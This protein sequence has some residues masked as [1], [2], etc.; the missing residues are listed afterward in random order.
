M[1]IL[2]LVLVLGDVAGNEAQQELVFLTWADY[3]DPDVVAEFEAEEGVKVQFVYF[4]SDF[5][6]NEILVQTQAQGFDVA[7]VDGGSIGVVGGRGWLMPVS[8]QT[9][10]NLAHTDPAQRMAYEGGQ[11]YGVPYTW[12]TIGIAY[13]ADLVEQ[14]IESWMQ[15]FRPEPALHGKIVMIEDPRELVGMALKA[16]GH[17]INSENLTELAEAER[18]LQEQR[19]LV[20]SYSYVSLTER[21]ALV[22]GE[23]AAAMVYNGDALMLQQYEPNI[24]FV[25][26]PEGTGMWVDYLAVLSSSP[27]KALAA[28]FIDFMNRPEIAA[29]NAEYLYYATPNRAA[30]RLLPSE[31]LADDRIYPNAE[32]PRRSEPFVTKLA[33][34]AVKARQKIYAR[35]QR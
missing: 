31:F 29:R 17:S 32:T 9:I 12:G 34:R 25:V 24:R 33:P 14:P 3:V 6:R 15:L 1:V 4:E 7:N 23:A 19:P 26:P 28:R 27:R 5:K 35:L 13:R 22:T 8:E 20:K 21:S 11:R 10:P 30:E 18:L 16:L 2:G